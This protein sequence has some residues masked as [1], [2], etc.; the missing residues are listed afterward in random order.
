MPF[1]GSGR[2]LRAGPLGP[3]HM[4]RG[5]LCHRGLARG[6]RR[7]LVPLIRSRGSRP[8]GA[9]PPHCSM[10]RRPH[11]GPTRL[12]HGTGGYYGSQVPP[13]PS[14]TSRTSARSKQHACKYLRLGESAAVKT[15][16]ASSSSRR[17]LVHL[18]TL[19]V[20]P[21]CDDY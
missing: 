3:L 4:P 9:Y 21:V 5:S 7:A 11:P 1:A 20:L 6:Q 2:L 13:P 19:Y 16:R 18:G 15:Q 14:Y 17:L 12:W 10:R 8:G